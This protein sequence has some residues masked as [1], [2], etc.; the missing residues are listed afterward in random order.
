MRSPVFAS[1]FRYRSFSKASGELHLTQ[2]TVSEHVRTLEGELGV[3][4]FDRSGRTIHPTPE[5]GT[6][7][8][9]AT[10]IIERLRDVPAALAEHRREL[11]GQV[12]LGGR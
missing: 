8:A 10:E 2:P 11:S 4:L 12:V 7:F 9:R 6:L 5:A 3:S 1:V